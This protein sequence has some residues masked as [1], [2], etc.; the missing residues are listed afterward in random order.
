MYN[1]KARKESSPFGLIF[2]AISKNLS[3]F[4]SKEVFRGC[5]MLILQ[6]QA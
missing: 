6:L 3:D 5:L 2:M 1:I 4:W